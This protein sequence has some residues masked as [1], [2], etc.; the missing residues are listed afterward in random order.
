MKLPRGFSEFDPADYLTD[1]EDVVEYLNATLEDG[2][3]Q[4]VAMALGAVARS[5]GMSKIARDTGL[6]RVSLYTSLSEEGNPSLNTIMKVLDTLGLRLTVKR[7]P[8]EALHNAAT[9]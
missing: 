5:E 9:E 6:N 7:K 1:P 4:E 3:A 8:K 2:T